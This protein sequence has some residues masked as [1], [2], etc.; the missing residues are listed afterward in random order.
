[1][2]IKNEL[3]SK[4]SFEW[5]NDSPD[6]VVYL[7]HQDDHELVVIT[8][9]QDKEHI[10]FQWMNKWNTVPVMVEVVE[11]FVLENYKQLYPNHS[12]VSINASDVY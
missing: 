11:E 7:N 8:Y 1:M 12:F 2:S 9:L 4:L 6:C 5:S 3:K 10:C